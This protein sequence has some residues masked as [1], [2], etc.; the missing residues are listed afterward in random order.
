MRTGASASLRSIP[1]ARTYFSARYRTGSGW[2]PSGQI[3]KGDNLTFDVEVARD[4]TM[5][6]SNV[7]QGEGNSGT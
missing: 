4:G 7:R 1:A 6:A 2:D 3:K 5:K